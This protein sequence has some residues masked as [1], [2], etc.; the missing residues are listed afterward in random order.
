MDARDWRH[1]HPLDAFRDDHLAI[2]ERIADLEAHLD[3]AVNVRRLTAES[4]GEFRGDA[5]FLEDFLLDHFRSEDES[6]LPAVER[7]LG[8]HGESMVDILWQEHEELR[9]A[10]RKFAEALDAAIPAAGG[11]GTVEELNRHGLFLVQVL[12]DHVRKE[13]LAFFPKAREVLTEAEWT[14]VA[15]RLHAVRGDSR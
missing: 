11:S 2:R 4:T 9:R 8:R 15:E 10:V 14:E 5:E 1:V 3:R 12:Q 6:L 7:H 13:E